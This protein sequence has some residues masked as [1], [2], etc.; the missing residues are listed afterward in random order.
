MAWRE[1]TGVENLEKIRVYELARELDT[2][3]KRLMEKLAEVGVVVKNHMSL[4]E[5]EELDSLY[6][7]IG[8][9]AKT[10][11]QEHTDPPPQAQQSAPQ[12]H[13]E[14]NAKPDAAAAPEAG[15]KPEARPAAAG[16]GAQTKAPDAAA[17]K[18]P[19]QTSAQPPAPTVGA[20][21]D[22]PGAT[23]A[24]P[25]DASKDAVK[26]G[27]K[28]TKKD[29]QKDA[30][31]TVSGAAQKPASGAAQK[32]APGAG[33]KEAKDPKDAKA[34]ARESQREAKAAR[35]AKNAPRIIR[36]T[37][38]NLDRAA[39][40]EQRKDAL[41]QQNAGGAGGGQQGQG[42]GMRRGGGGQSRGGQ[43][44]GGR[45]DRGRDRRD[46][47]GDFPRASESNSGLMAGFTRTTREKT[48]EQLIAEARL[49]QSKKKAQ[50]LAAGTADGAKTGA[51]TNAPAGA[52]AS[53][54]GS[55]A[56]SAGSGAPAADKAAQTQAQT[57]AADGGVDRANAAGAG[58]ATASA[59]DANAASAALPGGAS[60]RPD[61]TSGAAPE[62]VASQPT[63]AKEQ[64]ASAGV[65]AASAGTGADAAAAK[66]A[67]APA[68]R[69][70]A[71]GTPGQARTETS[72]GAAGAASAAS[73]RPDREAARTPRP[74]DGGQRPAGGG[75]RPADGGARRD[76]ARPY[77]SDRPGGSGGQQ[78][79]GGGYGG[80]RAQDGRQQNRA[81]FDGRPYAQRADGSRPSAPQR[82]DGGVRSGA[83]GGGYGG[84]R[85]QDG[86]PF[87]PRADGGQRPGGGYGGARTQDGRPQQRS[88]GRPFTPRTDG[89]ARPG[90]GYAGGQ[91]GFR[92]TGDRPFS[93][94]GG[95]RSG[96]QQRTGTSGQY[97]GQ[98]A[99]GGYAG[100]QGGGRQRSMDIPKPEVF[101]KGDETG[102]AKNEQ[103]REFL[104]KDTA[105]GVMKDQ[106]RDAAKPAVGGAATRNR[107]FRPE[108]SIIGEKKG[109]QAFTDDEFIINEFYNATEEAKRGRRQQRQRKLLR[110]EKYIPPR[111]ILTS[112]T[113]PESVTVKELAEALK[114]TAGDVIKKLMGMGMA[115]TINEVLDFDAATL[116]AAEFGI[117][118][119]KEVVINEEDILFDEAE[120]DEADLQPRP[121]IVVVMGH[122]DHGKTSLLDAIRKTNVISSEAGGIT[123]HIGA[124]MVNIKGKA[125]TFLDTPG[126][127]AFTSMRARGAM[128]TDVAILVVAA[129]DGV[130]PQTIEA[131]NHAKAAK[132]SIIV[133]INKIDKEGA[134]P[135]R[136]KQELTEYGIVV[137]EWGG[138]VIAVPVSAKTGENI[139]QLLEMVLLTA[140]VLELK[141]SPDRQAKGTVIEAKLDRARGPIAT[142]LVQRGT[143][144]VGDSFI[145]GT[146]VGRIRAMLDD[147]GESIRE[148]GPSTPVEI[149]GLSEVPEAGE[150]FYVTTDD[151]VTKSLAEKRRQS[152][153]EEQLRSSAR[154]TL[155]DL[156]TQIQAG[157]VKELNLII[158]ADVQGSV[159]AVRQ[160]LEKLGN[161]EVRI[162]IIHGGVGAISESDVSLANVSNAIIIGFNVRPGGA[163]V[164][165]AAE[166]A[167]VDVRLYTVIYNAIE[168]IQAA[169]KGMLDPTFREVVLGHVEIRQIFRASGVGTIGGCYVLDGKIQ[170]ANSVRI[171]RNGISIHDGKLASLRRFKDDAREVQQGFECGIAIE[172]FND[173]KENDI[174]EP[175]MMEEVPVE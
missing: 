34:S 7:H 150:V 118:T 173:I 104:S 54:G 24:A 157:S 126:H 174:I 69:E 99:G 115:A 89:G 108:T 81:S 29:A 85:T 141:S 19:P 140:D 145:T 70:A 144:R 152:Q 41:R 82:T 128:V 46:D 47:R 22:A 94:Q 86:R 74:A 175:Y 76:G 110:K 53:T 166:G 13:Q 68:A 2:N 163:A 16:G 136:V 138:D 73:A 102:S 21:A 123:Q 98:R 12:K 132:V 59:V 5:D 146:T 79:Q 27:G 122:V 50:A 156:F 17:P 130:M 159:E 48:I 56:A 88:D 129:D 14:T 64:Y 10:R 65:P 35:D 131:I 6:K 43:S 71:S 151:K 30:P 49:Q 111:A 4:L 63:A 143:L 1:K 23:P 93:S 155:D 100:G 125:I 15:E 153:R 8:I 114:K 147:K 44:R 119:E 51:G 160:S 52:G 42:G 87:T 38:I 107:R 120:A 25:K 57:Q 80:A 149:I 127:E 139:E 36:T 161:D 117:S 83:S 66:T 116:V 3:S 134:N 167:G 137:E 61:A 40:E 112:V 103:K 135:E 164:I 20:T 11:V 121:P 113:I 67:A 84:T 91:G 106:K 77:A 109:V 154:V 170:R 31:K 133:A 162:N 9:K 90:G 165:E 105:K 168:D 58:T 26:D 78:A 28:D 18:A 158:K 172:R 124:Y 171:I 148:A 39:R 33:A 62:P 60:V 37:E 169:M 96:P 75:Q 45:R 101:G 72:V 142:L 92:G 32:A 95:G 97:G 55:A